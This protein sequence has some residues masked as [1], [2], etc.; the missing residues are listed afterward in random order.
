LPGLRLAYFLSEDSERG[1]PNVRGK[2]APAKWAMKPFRGTQK[3]LK[4]TPARSAAQPAGFNGYSQQFRTPRATTERSSR[5]NR[6][7]DVCF[8]SRSWIPGA[9]DGAAPA[10]RTSSGSLPGATPPHEATPVHHG[11]RVATLARSITA[12]HTRAD[13]PARAA[14]GSPAPSAGKP[15][16]TSKTVEE[17]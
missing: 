17:A 11:A 14:A 10:K 4:A 6:S 2:L 7:S 12:K 13:A 1:V 5:R 9:A 15:S 3:P 8:G 16:R